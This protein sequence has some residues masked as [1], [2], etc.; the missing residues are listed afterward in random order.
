MLKIPA[1]VA[2]GALTMLT[3]CAPVVSLHPL[4]PNDQAAPVDPSYLGLWKECDGDDFWKVEESGNRA[5]RYLQLLKDGD[6]GEVRLM[7][8]EGTRFADVV[9]E[10]GA[11]RAH[12]L[13]RVR[14]AGDTLYLAFLNEKSASQALR[15]ET[16]ESGDGS[17]LVLTASTEELRKFLLAGRNQQDVFEQEA[18]FCRVK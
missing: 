12:V 18:A 8:L 16:V 15:H 10:G 17:Q 4:V 11:V 1:M 6:R 13:A 14:L 7:D 3:A 9:P 2:F 5:Y